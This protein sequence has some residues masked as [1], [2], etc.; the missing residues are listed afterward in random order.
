ML[1]PQRGIQISNE[2]RILER[3]RL[4]EYEDIKPDRQMIIQDRTNKNSNFSVRHNYST[5]K[6]RHLQ[7]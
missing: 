1:T 5:E 6:D 7:R 4:H 2:L 3:S